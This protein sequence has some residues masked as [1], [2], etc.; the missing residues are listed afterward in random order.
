MAEAHIHGIFAQVR[1]RKIK[2]GEWVQMQI[3]TKN[4]RLDYRFALKGEPEE[5]AAL[6]GLAPHVLQDQMVELLKEEAGL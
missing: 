4:V 1:T 5:L 2:D 6:I 3:R